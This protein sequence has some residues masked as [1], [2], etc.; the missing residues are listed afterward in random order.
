M[1]NLEINDGYGEPTPAAFLDRVVAA[2]L[3]HVER[4]EMPVSLLLT[5]D[6]GIASLH[7]RFLG[8]ASPTDV[9]S[10]PMDEGVDVVVSVE[11]AKREST[12]HGHAFEAEIALYIVHGILHACEYDDIAAEDRARMRGAE[13]EILA[14]LGLNASSVDGDETP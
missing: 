11:C 12:R 9:I 5:D 3:N 7:E 1:P 14:S 8:D 4:P 2:V 10:F 13:R 6:A